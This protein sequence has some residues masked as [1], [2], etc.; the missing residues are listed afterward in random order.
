MGNDFVGKKIGSFKFISAA[1]ASRISLKKMKERQEW[2]N[3]KT[4]VVRKKITICGP[5]G[6]DN[7]FSVRVCEHEYGYEKDLPAWAGAKRKCKC[8]DHLDKKKKNGN[9]KKR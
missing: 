7:T 8:F 4:K 1:E 6:W 9:N 5:C 3:K 2:L